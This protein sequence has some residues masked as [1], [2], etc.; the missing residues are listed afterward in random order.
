MYTPPI[1][2]PAKSRGFGNAVTVALNISDL[3]VIRKKRSSK[4]IPIPNVASM[5]ESS[6]AF[7]NGRKAIAST[8]IERI[9]PAKIDMIRAKIK[10]TYVVG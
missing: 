3:F 8:K 1:L 4:N 6:G 9:I 7:L 5:G 10:E 2:K